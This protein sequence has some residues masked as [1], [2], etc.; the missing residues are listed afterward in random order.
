M[1]VLRNIVSL[2]PN[3][4][5]HAAET[6]GLTAPDWVA[7]S[8]PPGRRLGSGGGTVHALLAAWRETGGGAAFPEWL[9][10]ERRMVTHAGG[11][12]RRLPAYAAAG[13]VLMPMPVWRWSRGQRLDQSLLD[14]HAEFSARIFAQAPAGIVAGVASGDALLRCA[15]IPDLP[16]GDVVALGL[17]V[18]AER[19]SRHGVFFCDRRPPHALRF[20]LQKPSPAT[21]DEQAHHR[22]FLIDSG[23]WLFSERALRVLF[24]KCGVDFDRPSEEVQAYE[25]YADFGLALGPESPVRDPA[26][27]GLEAAVCPL[28]EGG[29][30]H[31]GSG[32][33]LIDSTLEL[34]H[35]VADQRQHG[36]LSC[37]HPSVF[38][39]NAKV[40]AR[41]WSSQSSIWIENSAIGDRWRLVR[42]HIL[43]G[44]PE[45]DWDLHLPPGACLDV[46]PL[47]DGRLVPR[48]YGMDDEFR[49]PLGG[50]STL[51]LG[52]PVAQWLA[53]R[54]LD[55][56]AAGLDPEADIFDAPLFPALAAET[57]AG[58][59]VQ[60]LIGTGPE[61]SK[62]SGDSLNTPANGQ[63]PPPANHVPDNRDWR[64]LWRE[65]ERL[66]ARQL[67]DTADLPRLYAQRR[68]FRH[69][70]IPRL[71][72]N[73]A[74]S[75]FFRLDLGRLAASCADLAEIPDAAATAPTPLARAQAHAFQ[76]EWLACRKAPE[77]AIAKRRDLAYRAVRETVLEALGAN[78]LEPVRNLLPDQI[79]WAR[80]PVR[81]DLGGGWTDTP[82]FCFLAG[83]QVTNL[84]ADLNGQPP[85]QVFVRPTDEP[86]LRLRSIDL[87]SEIR[88]AT[89]AELAAYTDV[90]DP[91]A[92]G[93]GALALA[94]FLPPHGGLAYQSLAEQLA[95]F[96]GGLDISLL[97]AVPK[98]SGLGTSS[99]L[100]ATLLGA[101][102]EACG[103][104]WDRADL[105]GRTLALE[106]LLT[107]G[108]GWQDQAGGIFPGV[109][110]L[111]TG[112]EPDQTPVVRWLP[113]RVFAEHS[114]SILLY[115]TGITRVAKGILGQVVRQVLL[116]SNA[117]LRVLGEIGQAAERA[118]E[119]I[120]RGDYA[121]LGR[122]VDWS[123]ELNGQLDPGSYPAA[124]KSI[125]GPLQDWLFGAKLLGAGGGGYVLMF[126][127][128]PDA[129]Q[130]IRHHLDRHPPCPGSR[131]VQLS[132][133]ASGLQITRS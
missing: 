1:S 34:Q 21:I 126:A 48:V 82:P 91:F 111:T 15:E 2:P 38:I 83:A 122:V 120:Q 24:A 68:R 86:V 109:K 118:A 89:R 58:A 56:T 43:T 65:S 112:A 59:F 108:G 117:H 57:W 104:G 131:F 67:G 101:L 25:L 69:H 105:V 54:G 22:L 103:L 77:G 85:I 60:W 20:F 42:D 87:G 53:E 46:V 31:F 10:A 96:G 125:L 98:G 6:E 129:A 7:C 17:W 30:H 13:K 88:L 95:D 70:A 26:I 79:V 52:R 62:T 37:H 92:L 110:L 63:D 116:N 45:N 9:R 113:E 102:S 39:Q 19:A 97:A 84:A 3:G 73:H 76:A 121:Q 8:D 47:A 36:K 80:S 51:W 127:K 74:R 99:I 33:D 14:L 44:V 123:R 41:L 61:E 18:S 107:T 72:A 124:V 94:G 32:R 81:L 132:L 11:L 4:A 133:S 16:S 35:L 5:R 100:G 75:A 64:R 93:K 130:R 12:S 71:V 90:H 115:Y 128:D 114:Q 50:E 55:W 119:A 23:F 40:A 28:P 78:P 29:F 106:Q 27:N 49:G 66:S